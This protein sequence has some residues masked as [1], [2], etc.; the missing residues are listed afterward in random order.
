MTKLRR[1]VNKPGTYVHYALECPNFENRE[2]CKA[3]YLQ[4]SNRPLMKA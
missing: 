1:A 4:L 3:G 2:R